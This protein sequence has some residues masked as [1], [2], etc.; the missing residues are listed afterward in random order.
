M[1]ISDQ[2]SI[3]EF[4]NLKEERIRI[5]KLI[6]DDP[7]SPRIN[8]WNVDLERLEQAIADHMDLPL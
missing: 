3:D 7:E 1:A 6:A 8:E 4:R 2:Q 5:E